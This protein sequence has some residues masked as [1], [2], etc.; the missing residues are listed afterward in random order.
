MTASE[1]ST[2]A[3]TSNPSCLMDLLMKDNNN[4]RSTDDAQTKAQKEVLC[5]GDWLKTQLSHSHWGD[6]NV[7]FL[8]CGS[9]TILVLLACTK[10]AS[11]TVY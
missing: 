2:P 1:A 8:S 7:F 5:L 4:A 10:T 11:G 3:A 9:I 6:M